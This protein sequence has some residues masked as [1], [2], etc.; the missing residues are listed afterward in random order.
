MHPGRAEF[1]ALDVKLLSLRQLI[2]GNL[3]T[4]PMGL[5]K[6]SSVCQQLSSPIP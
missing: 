5:M 2:L 4:G 3:E 1:H 6:P